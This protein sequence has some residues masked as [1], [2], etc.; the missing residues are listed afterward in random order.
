M[1]ALCLNFSIKAQEPIK[2]PPLK[3]QGILGKVISATNGEVLPGAVIKITNTSQTLLGN[4]QGEFMLS[5]PNG[6]YNLSVSY[7]NHKTKIVSIQIPLKEKL[8][9]ALDVDDQNLKEVEINA[10]YYTVKDKE[11]TGS[12][13][14]ITAETIGKQ[15][16]NNLYAAMVGQMPGVQI[17]QRSG[18]PGGG[19]DIMIRGQNSLRKTNTEDGNL[20]FYV[21]D[22]VPF[23]IPTFG[24]SSANANI[25]R[26]GP[27]PLSTINPNDILSVEILKDAD[28]TAIYGSRGAN[29]VVL[30]TTKRGKSG[31]EKFDVNLNYSFGE[32]PFKIDLLNTKEYLEVRREAFVNDN[33]IPTIANAP[34]LL[35]WDQNRSTDWQEKLVGGTAVTKNLTGSFSGGSN[36]T[37]YLISGNYRDEGTVYPGDSDYKQGSSHVSINHISL[38]KKFKAGFS[39]M[40]SMEISNLPSVDLM[41]TALRLSPNAPDGYDNFGNLNWENYADNPY[42]LLQK[43]YKKNSSNLINNLSLGYTLIDG[44]DIKTSLSYNKFGSEETQVSPLTSRNPAFGYTSGL[45]YFVNSKSETFSIEPQIN[46][47]RSIGK[48]TITALIGATLQKNRRKGSSVYATGFPSDALLENLVSAATIRPDISTDIPYNYSAVF[49]RINLAYEGKYILNLTGRR[50][51]SSRFAPGARFANFGAVGAA[52]IFS[53]EDLFKNRLP[54]LSHGKIRT[55]YGVTGSDQIG[56]FKYLALWM[57]GLIYDGKTGLVPA[58]LQ[59]DNYSWEKNVK[60]EA[61]VELGFADDKI[62]FSISYYENKSSNQ[63][64]GYSL[65]PTAGFGTILANFPATVQNTGWELE[66]KTKNINGKQVKWSSSA[67]FT[68]PITKLTDFPNIEKTSYGATYQIG[69]PLSVRKSAIYRNVDGQTGVYLFNPP[70]FYN[71]SHQRYYGGL[72]NTLNYRS[73]EL[74]L[75]FQFVKQKGVNQLPIFY[76]A[77]GALINQPVDVLDRWQ[78]T[79]DVSIFQK[80]TQNYSGTYASLLQSDHRFSDASYIKLRNVQLSYLMPNR[81]ADKL[82]MQQIRIYAQ[83]QNLLT[84]SGYKGLDPETQSGDL[85]AL[86]ILAAGIQLTF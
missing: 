68:L 10:G 77:P 38:N 35:A 32:V 8:V 50:D 69:Q 29:G 21:I 36:L 43:Q 23:I 76:S 60:F 3:N 11:R 19:F 58:G 41:Q 34:D 44:L 78:K 48:A 51:G 66:L 79:G 70:Q 80:Y 75:D 52:W 15:P 40:Y 82:R 63:L 86:R 53:N 67:N 31:K 84:M 18:V 71:A 20:P 61:A 62:L 14:R 59:N 73:L 17:V 28:A 55:S 27:N 39:S 74:S 83:G 5:L 42:S 2:P 72:V 56:D 37:Q 22:G 6:N 12:I 9:I 64:V 45:S 13:S 57:P 47:T 81:L 85:P 25:T 26:Q 24:P 49:S 4:D 54:I 7:L 1:A 16:V 33:V 46:Y 65:A 30:I